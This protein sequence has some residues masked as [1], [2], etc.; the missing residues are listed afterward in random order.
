MAESY[1][2]G[3]GEDTI[4]ACRECFKGVGK[5]P[6]SE[7]GLPKAKQCTEQFLPIENEACASLI[8]ELTPN[9]MEKGE[10]VFIWAL[11]LHFHSGGEVINCFDETLETANYQRC[12]EESASTE[13]NDVLTDGA[14]CVLQS[15][16]FGHDYVKNV[17]R[18]S[19]PAG[20]RFQVSGILKTRTFRSISGEEGEERKRQREGEEGSLHEDDDDRS[21]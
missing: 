4:K 8:A 1:W 20:G 14:M 11:S 6:L 16:K 2:S 13:V 17:T 12:I 19:R 5:N 7:E 21:L 3:K 18:Q 10:I 9:D 15:W